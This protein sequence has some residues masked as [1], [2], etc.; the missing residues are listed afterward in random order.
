MI[1]RI[2]GWLPV[3]GLSAWLLVPGGASAGPLL[4]WC[5]GVPPGCPPGSYSPC[6]Y[7]AP[8]LVRC[9]EIHHS[10]GAYLYGLGPFCPPPSYKIDAFRCPPV[11]PAVFYP[12]AAPA[13]DLGGK[14][15]APPG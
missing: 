10:P 1:G 6:H 2:R 5:R 4:D 8:G 7:W 11:N 15:G 3:A 13:P 9:W 14:A 12:A